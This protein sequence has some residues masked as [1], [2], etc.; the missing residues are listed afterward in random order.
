MWLLLSS[1]RNE[2][3]F[4]LYPIGSF[5]EWTEKESA[6]HLSCVMLRQLTLGVFV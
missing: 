6:D 1:L 4:T 3:S 2:G 5:L